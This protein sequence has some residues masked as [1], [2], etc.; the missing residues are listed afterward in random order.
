MNNSSPRSHVRNQKSERPD[1]LVAVVTNDLDLRRF[2]DDQIYRIPERSIGRTL[3]RDAL[4]SLDTLALY[5]SS[6]ITEGLP[7]AIE[8]WA[9]VERIESVRRGEIFPEEPDHPSVDE[10][11]HLLHLQTPQQLDSPLR[12]RER[13]RIIFLRTTRERL[14]GAEDIADL[15]LGRPHASRL[16]D[17]LIKRLKGTVRESLHSFDSEY[18]ATV[19]V[20]DLVMEVESRLERV[21]CRIGSEERGKIGIVRFSPIEVEDNLE[22]CVGEIMRRLSDGNFTP[23]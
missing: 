6:R 3:A 21:E 12:S 9:E 11:Y 17:A 5:Q 20:D 16:T 10:L 14:L 1:T 19:R 7:S 13:R 22:G 23:G 8:W 15:P 4:E 2:L 18:R